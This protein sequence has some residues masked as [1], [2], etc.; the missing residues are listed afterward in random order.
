MNEIKQPLAR[1]PSQSW[2]ARDAVRIQLSSQ[3]LAAAPPSRVMPDAADLVARASREMHLGVKHKGE[4]VPAWLNHSPEL[5]HRVIALE[6]FGRDALGSVDLAFRFKFNEQ[7]QIVEVAEHP[8]AKHFY[9]FR[10]GWEAP[11]TSDDGLVDYRTRPLAHFVLDVFAY[12][13]FL[14]QCWAVALPG[15][16]RPTQRTPEGD[17]YLGEAFNDLLDALRAEAF[18]RQIDDVE[19]VQDKGAKRANDRMWAYIGGCLSQCKRAYVASMVF[20]H[21]E[22]YGCKVSI[23][24]AMQHHATF[25]NR[26]RARAAIKQ[27]LI[28]AIWKRDWSDARGHHYRWILIF[29]GELVQ[30]AWE[31]TDLIE[32]QWGNVVPQGAGYAD[33]VDDEEQSGYTGMIELDGSADKLAALKA[34]IRY[35]AMKDYAL[36]VEPLANANAWGTFTPGGKSRKSA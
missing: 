21:R 14:K 10:P 28:G 22:E 11:L 1:S 3:D 4:P 34:E 36:C 15:H 31:W 2:I 26:L 24:L 7:G 13:P 9:R 27:R 6:Q 19:I 32:A 16:M 30:A 35:L 18:S 12:H 8:L 17:G 5:E 33:A 20:F 23:E 25:T 29:D